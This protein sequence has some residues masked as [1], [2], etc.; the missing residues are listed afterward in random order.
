MGLTA[1]YK[2]TYLLLTN[3]VHLPIFSF[4]NN[5]TLSILYFQ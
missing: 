2:I 4:Y 1:N 5:I 3:T